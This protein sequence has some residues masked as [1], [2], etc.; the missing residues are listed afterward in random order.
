M[1]KYWKRRREN[2]GKPLKFHSTWK[3]S[4]TMTN[5]EFNRRFEV[6]G[7]TEAGGS[8]SK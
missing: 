6:A 2:G 4:K 8:G 3:N 7:P 1:K 5:E